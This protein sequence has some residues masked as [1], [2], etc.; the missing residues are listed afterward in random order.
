MISQVFHS[1]RIFVAENL[2]IFEKFKFLK[3]LD[4]QIESLLDF[5]GSVVLNQY[6]R[7]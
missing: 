4:D 5:K 1:K 2:L 3:Y 7:I 6:Q